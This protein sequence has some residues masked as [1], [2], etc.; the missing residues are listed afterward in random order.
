[1]AQTHPSEFPFDSEKN[2]SD[3][4]AMLADAPVP[5]SSLAALYYDHATRLSYVVAL[6]E[7]Q[8]RTD[9]LLGLA[10]PKPRVLSEQKESLQRLAYNL[11]N[12]YHQEIRPFCLRCRELPDFNIRDFYFI[13]DFYSRISVLLWKARDY[14]TAKYYANQ[15]TQALPREHPNYSQIY[16]N[17][18]S[19]SNLYDP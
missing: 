18:R 12:R 15:S 2:T 14:K 9:T 8:L 16:S 17:Y 6:Q 13:W 11:I 4:F 7:A 10:D 1:M 19:I 5:S 3:I